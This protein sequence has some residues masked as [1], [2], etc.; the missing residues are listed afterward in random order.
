MCCPV[1][2]DCNN[3]GE[4]LSI[5]CV[6]AKSWNLAF[7]APPPPPTT[8]DPP[9]ATPHDQLRTSIS[10]LC[11]SSVDSPLISPSFAKISPATTT[12]PGTRPRDN[13]PSLRRPSTPGQ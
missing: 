9:P 11:L 8:P 6:N 10:S 2:H 3:T 7:P 4:A 1:A 5:L 12:S 13:T